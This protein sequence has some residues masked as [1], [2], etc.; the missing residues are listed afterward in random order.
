MARRR[1][2]VLPTFQ[3]SM[4]R[5]WVLL[6]LLSSAITQLVTLGYIWYQDRHLKGEYVYVGREMDNFSIV[7]NPPAVALHHIVLPSLVTAL[8][9]GFAM[10]LLAGVFYSHRLAGP[11][12]HIQKTLRD[13]ADGK[14]VQPIV[15]R[16]NDEFKELA[17]AI[18]LL[19][20]Q[21]KA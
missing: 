18:N 4:V 19:L 8:G 6:A 3:T 5:Q 14:L 1:F 11:I 13:A 16:K 20:L 9:L 2:W 7:V 10:S 12:Y 21:R 17:E 15:L